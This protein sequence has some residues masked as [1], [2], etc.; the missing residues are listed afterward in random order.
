MDLFSYKVTTLFCVVPGPLEECLKKGTK[1]PQV[2]E[3]DIATEFF[4]GGRGSYG[5]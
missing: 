2:F 5:I 4:F 3:A 1:L